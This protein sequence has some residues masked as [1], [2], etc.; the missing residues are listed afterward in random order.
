MRAYTL[1]PILRLR[2][3]LMI[4]DR[5]YVS[6][7]KTPSKT[8]QGVSPVDWMHSDHARVELDKLRTR[9]AAAFADTMTVRAF[10]TSITPLTHGR[11]RHRP[12]IAAAVSNLTTWLRHQHLCH[13]ASRPPRHPTGASRCSRRSPAALSWLPSVHRLA[14]TVTSNAERRVMRTRTRTVASLSAGRRRPRRGMST[15][16]TRTE[17]SGNL[18]HCHV[19]ALLF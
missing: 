7:K 5:L 13:V 10:L 12:P 17:S 2:S 16:Q 1:Q 6:P 18:K 19:R 8:Q 11:H 3:G 14:P 9:M 15:C 4:L